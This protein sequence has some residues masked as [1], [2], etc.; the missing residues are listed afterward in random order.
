MLIVLPISEHDAHLL[1][2]FAR[3]LAKFGGAK[4]AEALIVSHVSNSELIEQFKFLLDEQF[5]QIN[6]FAFDATGP[7]GWPRSC[8][9]YFIQTAFHVEEKYASKHQCFYFMEVDTLPLKKGWYE[10]L[11][12]EYR[13]SG[14][15]FMGVKEPTYLR[16]LDLPPDESPLFDGGF[17]M[18][19][20]GIYPTQ[21]SKYSILYKY[22]PPV[23]WDVEMQL[24]VV[25]NMHPTNLIQHNWRTHNYREG[26]GSIICDDLSDKAKGLSHNKAVR[27]DAYLLHGCK[28]GSLAKLLVSET[29]K[30]KVKK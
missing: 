10:A 14:K 9:H 28:D 4:E 13:L 29:V 24:E 21:M 12:T 7:K 17:H 23:A 27:S 2:D 30:P 16:R 11:L 8:N 6:T 26:Y 15:P 1:P 18:V 22:N 20:T 5:A 19:G 3:V 25:P